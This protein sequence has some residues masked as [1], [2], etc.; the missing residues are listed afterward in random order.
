MGLYDRDYGRDDERTPWDRTENPRNITITLIV[1][2]AVAFLACLIFSE[3]IQIP[4]LPEVH[5]KSEL[6]AWLAIDGQTLVRPW[7]WWQLLTYGF[8]HDINGI[9]HLL[10]NMIALFFF[11]RTIEQRLGRMEFL[12]FYLLA[13]VI[14]G[15]IG[16]ASSLIAGMATGDPVTTRTIGASGA[17]IATTILFACYYPQAE[18]LLMFVLPVKAWVL[19]VLFVTMDLAGAFGFVRGMGMYSNTAFTVHLA[20]AFFA[21]GYYL[22]RWNLR[23]LDLTAIGELPQ[24]LRQR[25]RRM[26]LKLHDPDKKLEQEAAEAD[27]ILAK[28]HESGEASLTS[29]ERKTLERYSRRQREKRD[30]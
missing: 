16:S 4:G 2:N 12:R 1:I 13:I 23:W 8:L 21:L 7:M 29:S 3:R 15:I 10:F 6:I 5:R 14:G 19:A 30:Q 26:K 17:V 28:I 27:R 20:G 18:I 24:R 22:R 9:N 11:G 25:S